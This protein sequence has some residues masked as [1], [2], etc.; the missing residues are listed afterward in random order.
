MA[1]DASRRIP[2]FL[3]LVLL[4]A[5][6]AAL[7]ADNPNYL[8]WQGRVDGSDILRVRGRSVQVRHQ[9]AQPIREMRAEFSAPLPARDVRVWLDVK[10]GRG[11]IELQQQPFAGNNYTAVILVDD[12]RQPGSADYEFY[13]YWEPAN[14]YNP[15]GGGGLGESSG[16]GS[17]DFVWEGRV[18]G[19][20]YL[21]VRDQS[22]WVRHLEALPVEDARYDF[23]T[24]LPRRAQAVQLDVQRGRG[25]VTIEEQPSARNNYTLKI[26]LD[27]TQRGGSDFYRLGLRWAGGEDWKA[28]PGGYRGLIRW[29]G[30]V[31]GRDRLYFTKR[32]V[33]VRHL[34]AQ[35]IR[36]MRV[37][38]SV[39][40]P[41]EEVFVRLTVVRGRGEVR[42]IEQPSRRN[43]YAVEVEVDDPKNGADD[44]E[45]ELT[46]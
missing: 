43:G 30:T 13:L 21:F 35:P 36:D 15:G 12:E 29:R 42:L 17:Y 20:D 14:G 27:D 5:G 7:A 25:R 31:D 44:Y 1:T 23:R 38:F 6:A 2:M 45:F 40:L 46:W 39:P 19:A 41:R 18:D 16:F 24:A 34:D 37:E 11:R 4:L 32:A 28:P 10:Q 9:T 3:G 26:L 33:D 8:R 22:A